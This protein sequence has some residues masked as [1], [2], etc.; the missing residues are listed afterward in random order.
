MTMNKQSTNND[1]KYL[2]KII[3]AYFLKL[4]FCKK[5]TRT[6]FLTGTQHNLYQKTN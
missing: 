6:A 3:F 2:K 5:V 1:L 4:L